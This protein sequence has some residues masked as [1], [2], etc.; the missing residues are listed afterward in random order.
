M[1]RHGYKGR[2]LG[3]ERGS[4]KALIKGLAESLVIHESI[5]TTV[6]KAKEVVSY[7]EKL[8][9]KAKKGGLHNRRQIISAL[10]TYESASKL[11]DE[12]A[13]KLQGRS[14]GYFRIKRSI[15][16]RGDGTQMAR[17][18]FVDDLS[19]AK[20]VSVKKATAKKPV[21]KA[22]KTETPEEDKETLE[23]A[24]KIDS[25]S[26]IQAKTSSNQAARRAGRRGNR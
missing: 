16:R 23:T 5:E 17:V 22:A 2:K 12:L 6:P 13:P 9:T 4:R 10:S 11:V 24:R 20:P 7:T 18:T 21:A 1:H 8:I 26:K 3:R 14:S 25:G 19:Q 15:V